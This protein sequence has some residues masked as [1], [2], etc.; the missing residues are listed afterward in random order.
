VPTRL[1]VR[2]VESGLVPTRTKAQRLVADSQ[3][4]VDGKVV[5]KASM[6]VGESSHV[7]VS[8][9]ERYVSRGAHKLLAAFEDFGPLGLPSPDGRLCLDIGASTGGFSQVLL[10][11]GAEQVIA[12]DVGHGQLDPV[13]R[14]NPKVIE[15]SGA[16]IRA[17]TAESLP[18]LPDYVVCD[19]SFI[20]LTYVVPVVARIVDPTKAVEC[21]LLVKPQFEVGKGNL[22]KK[23]IVTS[24]RRREASLEKVKE[25]ASMN[26]F[27]VMASRPSPV[28]GMH[29]NMEYLLWVRKSATVP[30]T[31]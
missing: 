21:I 11:N 10:E 15:M 6:M 5:T 1:D 30:S 13:V 7:E 4:R 17:I 16:N 22:G 26:G 25:C 29:G 27:E 28:V 24:Q 20:S 19:V 9:T 31:N 3:V 12:L 8:D 14:S 2:L 23:G 18:Y